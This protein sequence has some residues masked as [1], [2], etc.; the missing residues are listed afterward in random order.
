MI[1]Y[2]NI[3]TVRFVTN[4]EGVTFG[5]D[6]EG[7]VSVHEC[8]ISFTDLMSGTMSHMLLPWQVPSKY[9]YGMNR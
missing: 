5:P 3:G 8:L 2:Y 9:I 4:S 6:L 7:S 1:R